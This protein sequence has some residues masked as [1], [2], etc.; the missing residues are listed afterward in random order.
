MLDSFAMLARFGLFAVAPLSATGAAII[1]GAQLV[2]SW[3]LEDRSNAQR[4]LVRLGLSLVMLA[5]LSWIADGLLPLPSA[6]IAKPLQ[7]QRA[8]ELLRRGPRNNS[9]AH[10]PRSAAAIVVGA[11]LAHRSTSA[12]RP[13]AAADGR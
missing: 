4:A 1:S 11:P 5:A 6:S 2:N 13:G 12:G 8:S 10:F 7:Q 3:S 9:G